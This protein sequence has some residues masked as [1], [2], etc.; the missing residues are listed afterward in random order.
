M[1]DTDLNGVMIHN[2]DKFVAII[3]ENTDNGIMGKEDR[4]MQVLELLVESELALPPVVIFRNAKLRGATFERNTTNNY[5]NELA[6]E[7]LIQKI[8]AKALNSGNIEKIETSQEGY[9]IATEK[10]HERLA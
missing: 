4:K 1:V 5:L 10:G 2:P 9:F 6:D 7:G 3:N 8:D